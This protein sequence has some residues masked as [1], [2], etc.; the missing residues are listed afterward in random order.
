MK[1]PACRIVLTALGMLLIV[2]CALA[3]GQVLE[4]GFLLQIADSAQNIKKWEAKADI[5]PPS[6]LPSVCLPSP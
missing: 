3:N 1:N 5:L 4:Q 2:P 6:G